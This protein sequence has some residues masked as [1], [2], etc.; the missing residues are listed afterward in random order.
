MPIDIDSCNQHLEIKTGSIFDIKSELFTRMN[1]VAYRTMTV[2]EFKRDIVPD[3]KQSALPER[4]H[5]YALRD[6]AHGRY[7]C[8]QPDGVE[9]FVVDSVE[10]RPVREFKDAFIRA[11]GGVD[12][13]DRHMQ[14]LNV[15]FPVWK[16]GSY[17]ST[18]QIY[19]KLPGTKFRFKKR[20]SRR[21][22][23]DSDALKGLF[24]P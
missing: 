6:L 5:K 20:I 2:D 8:I 10:D 18:W 15:G 1:V 14:L 24:T 11:E 9:E 4:F 13:V 17:D 21:S 16:Y 22:S 12:T 23:L 7:F 19:V 3:L